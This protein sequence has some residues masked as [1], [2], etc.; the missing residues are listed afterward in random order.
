MQDLDNEASQSELD[1][2]DSFYKEIP[3]IKH[4]DLLNTERVFALRA[5]R[6]DEVDTHYIPYAYGIWILSFSTQAM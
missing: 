1:A 6:T 2:R 4:R 3:Q 5:L